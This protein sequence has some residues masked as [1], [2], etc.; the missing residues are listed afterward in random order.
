MSGRGQ[1]LW[2]RSEGV[3]LSSHGF[4]AAI[5]ALRGAGSQLTEGRKQERRA[6]WPGSFL[7]NH[8][9]GAT[10]Y[11]L[12]PADL[13]EIDSTLDLAVTAYMTSARPSSSFSSTGSAQPAISTRLTAS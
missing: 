13:F 1:G 9:W 5:A 10:G 11:V 4:S 7:V 2:T 6:G 8:L 3:R 12:V